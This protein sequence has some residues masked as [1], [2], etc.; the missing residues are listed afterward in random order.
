MALIVSIVGARP[1]FI[2]CAP[3]SKKIREFFDEILVHTGQHYDENMSD[4]FFSEL[5][6]PNPD[7]NLQIGSGS[8][9]EQT[10]KMLEAIEKILLDIEPDLVLVYGDTNSTIAGAL[11]AS[12]LHIPV[13]HVEAGLRSFDRMMPEEVNRVLTDHISDLLFCPTRISGNNLEKEGITKGVFITGDV[14]VDALFMALP[15]ARKTSDILREI[16]FSSG[17][18]YLATIHRPSNTDNDA[19]LH[20]ILNAFS[21]LPYPV[22]FPVHPRTKK[23]LKLFNIKMNFFKNIFFINPQPYLDMVRLLD[24][25]RL[26]L[27]DSGG[28]QKEA[29]I[30]KKPCV[31]LRDTTEWVETIE[32]GW[33]I[34]A[35]ANM[36]D[37]IR[38]VRF[39]DG[40]SGKHQQCYGDGNASKEIEKRIKTFLN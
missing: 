22:I 2:K 23:C 31:T 28:V 38:N 14:M 21:M 13:A 30:L 27:T 32:E 18:Y 3:V 17:T 37:I 10:G 1:Q 19:N 26:V 35:G 34:L 12:K 8:H 29:Y 6:I 25:S 7:Y 4:V 24:G 20:A 40:Y 16:G 36:D 33:N 5:G 39:L 15:I 11:A 9:G